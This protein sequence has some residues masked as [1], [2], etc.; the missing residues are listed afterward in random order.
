MKQMEIKLE[1]EKGQSKISWT[2][3]AVRGIAV[4]DLN[5][6]SRSPST[7]AMGLKLREIGDLVCYISSHA[8]RILPS[9]SLHDIGD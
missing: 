2:K 4:S 5:L 8:G 7:K 9:Y 3:T 1:K 6:W